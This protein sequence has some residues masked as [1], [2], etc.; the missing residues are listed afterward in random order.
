VN[1]LD[2]EL[3]LEEEKEQTESQSELQAPH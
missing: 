2:M 3:P 1:S